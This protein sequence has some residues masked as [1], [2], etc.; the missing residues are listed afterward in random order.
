MAER[1]CIVIGAGLSGL[2]AADALAR[3][4]DGPWK[5]T[6]LE[7]RDRLGGRVNSFRFHEAPSL[8]CELGGEWIGTDHDHMLSLCKR[9]KLELDWHRYDFSFMERGQVIARYKSGDIPF[10]TKARKAF[11]KLKRQSAKWSLAQKKVLDRK[12]WW[13][14][15]RDYQF[16]TGDLLRRDLMDSTDFGESIRHAGGFS[17]GAEY[18][19]SNRYD[20][21]D[22]HIRGG[23][24]RLVKALA[25]S[26]ISHC[27][28][29]FTDR[30]VLRVRQDA[31]GVVVKTD[32][33]EEFSA[34]FCICTVPSRTLT[35]IHFEHPMPDDQWDAAKQLQYA[36]IQKSVLLYETRFWTSPRSKD[37]FSCFTD[38]A[39]D[40]IFDSTLAQHGA[41]GILCSYA[42]GDKA[43]DLAAA[44]SENLQKLIDEDLRSI[45][46]G[47][48]VLSSAIERYAWQRD[49]Y[50]E[51]AYALYRPG[52]WF[53]L[54]E[55]LV[56]PHGRIFFAGEHLADEQGFMEGAAD[57]GVDSAHD[58]VRASH[59]LPWRKRKR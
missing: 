14:I 27:G 54:W 52:Q 36:R 41:Q 10:P 2:C 1:S 13:T 7:A 12:D 59:G 39:S 6:V 18:F 32:T 5:V 55:R 50:T 8:V 3:H 51:G 43:D 38:G 17:A 49:E 25:Q 53:D 16:S 34:A 29:I 56:P 20:E 45:F 21:M 58:V 15:L 44:R 24:I 37:G 33:G 11:N 23:N 30:K 35:K 4:R 57:S 31:K 47:A 48:T 42:I 22:K 26:L 28:P 19:T 40:Y 46:P 9:F